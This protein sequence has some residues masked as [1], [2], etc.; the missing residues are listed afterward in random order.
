[1][2]K[3]YDIRRPYILSVGRLI[4]RKGFDRLIEAFGQLE[5]TEFG[6]MQLVIAGDGPQ[7]AALQNVVEKELIDSSVLFLPEV[8]HVDLPKLYAGATVFA[9][10]PREINGDIEGFGLVYLEAA[11]QGT[12]AVAT[13]TGGVSEAVIDGG[14]G[15]VVEPEN[16]SAVKQALSKLLKDQAFREKLG[17]AAK[18]RAE[19]EFNWTERIK[20]IEIALR[21]IGE[22]A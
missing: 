6:N 15:I 12:P 22:K 1:V 11:A 7:L 5:Q 9:L 19:R 13:R 4:E 18:R 17:E 3:K 21:K 16:I 20:V 14:T 2:L 8:P 10:T